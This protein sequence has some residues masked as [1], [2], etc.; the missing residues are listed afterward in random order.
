MSPKKN[1]LE[2]NLARYKKNA[3]NLSKRICELEQVDEQR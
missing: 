1:D 3:E 2:E